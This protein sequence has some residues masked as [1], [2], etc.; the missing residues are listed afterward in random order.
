[1]NGEIIVEINEQ[2]MHEK[3]IER[4]NKHVNKRANITKKQINEKRK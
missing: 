3:I 2:K 4:P 1:M